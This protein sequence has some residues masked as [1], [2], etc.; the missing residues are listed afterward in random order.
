MNFD[1]KVSLSLSSSAEGL[2]GKG[3]TAMSD[4]LDKAMNDALRQSASDRKSGE[5]KDAQAGHLWE[6]LRKEV[7][8]GAERIN[9]DPAKVRLVGGK[10]E[11]EAV[12]DTGYQSAAMFQVKNETIPCLVLTVKNCRE[13][14]AVELKRRSESRGDVREEE[15]SAEMLNMM[16][17]K[18]GHLFTR[19][20][21][22]DPKMYDAESL[23][24]YLF[25]KFWNNQLH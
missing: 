14:F 16:I 20:T 13:F 1:F 8:Q 12:D 4:K 23:T 6:R 7:R 10:L 3:V 11:Y 9:G 2:S 24:V 17:D 22:L 25:T 5:S 19:A 21:E 18:S 15:L